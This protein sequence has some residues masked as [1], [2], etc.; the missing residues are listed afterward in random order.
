[1]LLFLAVPQYN[2][3]WV[4]KKKEKRGIKKRKEVWIWDFPAA[5]V[6]KTV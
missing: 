5:P 3:V 1:M 2:M 6:A 4:F